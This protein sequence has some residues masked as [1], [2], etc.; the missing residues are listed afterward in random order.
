MQR[1][2]LLWICALIA[3]FALPIIYRAVLPTGSR[4][5]VRWMHALNEPGSPVSITSS[6]ATQ[7]FYFEH[8]K[9]HNKSNTGI[10]SVTFGTIMYPVG[11]VESQLRPVSLA[12]PEVPTALAPGGEQELDIYAAR[13]PEVRS[14]VEQ[15]NWQGAYVEL[16]VVSVQFEDGSTWR[17]TPMPDGGFTNRH[18]TEALSPRPSSSSV[19]GLPLAAA[20]L[21]SSGPD[22]IYFY[23]LKHR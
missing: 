5:D 14:R 15:L 19:A 7:N 4:V 10:S 9:L 13:I 1:R 23:M 22:T 6:T 2:L 3:L 16:G 20:F 11:V 21:Q 17:F 8:V 12:F 18:E